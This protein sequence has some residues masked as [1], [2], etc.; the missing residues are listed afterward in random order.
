M[1]STLL[2]ITYTSGAPCPP[3]DC[4]YHMW[5]GNLSVLMRREASDSQRKQ[6]QFDK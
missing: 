5:D 4:V 3:V 6:N 1:W 2:N